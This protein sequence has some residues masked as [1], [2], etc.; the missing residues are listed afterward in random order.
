MFRHSRIRRIASLVICLALVLPMFTSIA[1]AQ[2]S[3]GTTHIDQPQGNPVVNL[4]APYIHQLWDTG[5]SFDGRWA[6]GPT[7]AVMALAAYRKLLPTDPP[8]TTSTPYVH[9]NA[10]GKYVFS[11]YTYGSHTFS[12]TRYD[13]SGHSATGAYGSSLTPEGAAYY[14]Y[15]KQYLEKHDIDTELI[16][17]AH[18]TADSL[19]KIKQFLNQGHLVILSTGLTSGS[20]HII[21]VKG[22]TDDNRL[23]VHDPYG[24]KFGANGYGKYDG[25]NVQYT[26][27]QLYAYSSPP[28]WMIAVK[29][30][31]DTDDS[32][33]LTSGQALS[34][35]I[36]PNNDDDI[37][38]FT[39][40]SG[41]VIRL[42]MNKTSDSLDPFLE[43][44]GPNGLVTHNDDANGVLNSQIDTTL[45]ANGS[46]R[47][48]AHSYGRG[49]SGGYALTLTT[50]TTDGDDFRWLIMNNPLHG[51]L[52]PNN[53]RDT[54]YIWGADNVVLSI[55]MNRD[56]APLD[57]YLELYNPNGALVA[58]NDDGGG[59]SNS[60]LVYR[61]PTS[62][63]YRLVARSYNAGSGG[64]YTLT[65]S[66][67]RGVNYAL[68]KPVTISSLQD[69]N[70]TA[71]YATDGNRNTRWSSGRNLNQWIYVDLGQTVSVSQVVIRWERARATSY[72]IHYWNGANWVLLR[73]VS[74]GA[75][76]VDAL[77]FNTVSTRYVLLGCQDVQVAG[78]TTHCGS[79]RSTIRLAL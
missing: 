70:Y 72:G 41:S 1:A 35:V 9:T 16:D 8:L 3:V 47:V 2:T 17:P 12:Q 55:R 42:T 24:N 49:S 52:N 29:G 60:W 32:R 33:T 30:A 37:Y 67:V 18:F 13:A 39:G 63:Q 20:G 5:D 4:E 7:S 68:N 36:S 31:I 40:T 15:I 23:I 66:Y 11:T 48:V 38:T 74:N 77:S 10:Y 69:S 28:K 76:D 59:N 34:G 22:Y 14:G 78:A 62:G 58:L 71:A 46:Y 51:I 79:L 44:Y 75:G 25:A 26:W 19:D 61:F 21:L 73:S 6:C 56:S 65:A 27:Q 50:Q 43:L 53:D 54:Y 64:G 57:S 45:P